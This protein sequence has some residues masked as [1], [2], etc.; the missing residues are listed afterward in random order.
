MNGCLEWQNYSIRKLSVEK[1]MNDDVEKSRFL[2]TLGKFKKLLRTFSPNSV[3][4][5]FT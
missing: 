2:V 5:P 4:H 1:I 3:R